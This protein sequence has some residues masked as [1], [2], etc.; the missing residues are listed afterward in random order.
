MAE[1]RNL[2][3]RSQSGWNVLRVLRKGY[4]LPLLL[5]IDHTRP[6][7]NRLSTEK[8]ISERFDVKKQELILEIVG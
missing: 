5:G 4:D 2:D 8:R 6:D 1:W 7:E 3:N